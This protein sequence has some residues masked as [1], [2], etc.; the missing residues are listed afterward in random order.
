MS[1]F[2]PSEH[3]RGK[4]GRFIAKPVKAVKPPE[5]LNIPR[6]N[7]KNTVIIPA[8]DSPLNVQHYDALS[9]E[10][11]FEPELVAPGVMYRVCNNDIDVFVRESKDAEDIAYKIEEGF[12]KLG[13]GYHPEILSRMVGPWSSNWY[14]PEAKELEYVYWV[15]SSDESRKFDD[16]DEAANYALDLEDKYGSNLDIEIQRRA[17]TKWSVHEIGSK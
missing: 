6:K 17:M 16:R 11:Y 13:D 14:I 2:K 9:I 10:E 8:N 7:N 5:A 3:P 12:G 15:Y 4:S 1:K